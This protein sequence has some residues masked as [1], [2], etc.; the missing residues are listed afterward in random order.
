MRIGPW[1][2]QNQ[3]LSRRRFDSPSE[4]V[5]WFGAIQAQDY[6]GA[7]WALGSRTARATEG[8][9]QTA[10]D[11]GSVIRT[12]GFRC[13]WQFVT[14]EDLGWMLALVGPR[15]IAS[16]ASRFRE[17]GLD[18]K[19][20]ERSCELF[21]DALAD[22]QELTRAELSAVLSRRSIKSAG[23]LSHVLVHAELRGVICSG[24]RRGKQSTF[25]LLSERAPKTKTLT[26]EQAL[27]E[28]ARKYFRSR[29]PAT[30]RDLAW[31]SGLP[32]RDVREAIELVK[33]KL[34]AET[35]DGQQYFWLGA[36]VARGREPSV[37]LLPAFDEYLI[38]Y[39]D[40]SA[41]ID[42]SHVRSINAG[43]GILKPVVV[44]NGRVLGTWQRKLQKDA[45]FVSVRPLRKLLV[46][47]RDAVA[48]AAERYAGFLGLPLSG[49]FERRGS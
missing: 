17:V 47:E 39:Q 20:L 32:L 1:R 4:V 18:A 45:V 22:G 35:F 10:L 48:A 38:A 40:R 12:H 14:P 9:V 6:L 26:R 28:L 41:C 11:E 43:G 44:S 8:T 42:P 25:A 13:T 29:G 31:W 34:D 36:A 15:V 49:R 19:T 27:S 30:A 46:N 5:T 24:A 23:R 3:L 33:R 16:A 37:H 7:L 21:A 2:L